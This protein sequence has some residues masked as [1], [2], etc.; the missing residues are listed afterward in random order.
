MKNE[1]KKVSE[2]EKRIADKL[3]NGDKKEK[4][5]F[6]CSLN[7]EKFEKFGHLARWMRE[8]HGVS[9]MKFAEQLY[10]DTKRLEAKIAELEK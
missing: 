6:V 8:I 4:A 7:N 3:G 1:K 9:L 2:I 10:H 5:V